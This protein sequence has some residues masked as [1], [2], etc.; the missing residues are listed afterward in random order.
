MRAR[1]GPQER[2]RARYQRGPSDT[3][4][5]GAL[6]TRRDAALG[7]SK[8][9][10][11][12]S[13]RPIA[14][15][16]V[17]ETPNREQSVD[18]LDVVAAAALVVVSTCARSPNVRVALLALAVG[19]AIVRRRPPRVAVACAALLAVL[20]VG[21]MAR[22]QAAWADV[23]SA[24]LGTFD[25]VATVVDD[26]QPYGS[27]TRA[28][29]RIDGER[30]ETWGFGRGGAARLRQWRAGE[31]IEVSGTRRALSGD[32]ALRVAWQHVVGRFDLAWVADSDR[33]TPLAR[34]S[35]RV[36]RQIEL[37]ADELPDELGPLYRGLVIGDDRDQPEAMLDRFRASGLSHLT[38]V[39]GQNVAL[40]LA[41]AG[42]LLRRLSPWWRWGAT[43]ALIAWFAV[44][45]R[46][47]PSILRAGAMGLL[48]ATAFLR[49]RPQRSIRMLSLAVIALV[50]LDPLLVWSVGFWLSVGATAGVVTL[51]P[52]LARRL[53]WCGPLA[54]PLGITLGA[55]LGVALPSVLI[56]GRLPL[57]SVPAN[58]LAVPVA[59]VVMLYGLPAGLLAA[60]LPP[61]DRLVMMPVGVGVRWIDTVALV[62]S[63]LEP[64]PQG[65][66][67]GWLALVTA[68]V[69]M[70]LRQRR[71]ADDRPQ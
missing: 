40:V 8:A 64:A 38:A 51:G 50:L 55:Q 34:M 66:A 36:R 30:F 63:R 46:F 41:A 52:W 35:N 31:R 67:V 33:G 23:T 5:R 61:V 25:G 53:G 10:K 18:D 16:Y 26:P 60:A 48:T 12:L 24:Q 17:S 27:S 4:R 1:T 57:V 62:A 2:I 69:V 68:V 71:R 9:S 19:W 32:R 49:G 7:L 43:C 3:D 58:I 59:G 20:A 70:V 44:L 45:T 21:G 28:I 29:L 56:F 11:E 13:E 65:A 37:A 39:S 14:T 22:G 42:P 15:R 6:S 47:E 54:L